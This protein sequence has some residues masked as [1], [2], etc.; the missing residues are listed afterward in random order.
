MLNS[1]EGNSEYE[2]YME[3]VIYDNFANKETKIKFI[4]LSKENTKYYNKYMSQ[5]IKI[6]LKEINVKNL[7]ELTTN[8]Q[9]YYY[10]QGVKLININSLIQKYLISYND[11]K[12]LDLLFMSILYSYYTKDFMH[13]DIAKKE[14]IF[15]KDYNNINKIE[16]NNNIIS[17]ILK[18][19]KLYIK[20][21]LKLIKF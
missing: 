14:L 5:N 17:K 11:Y 19:S 18:N 1:N 9:N 10:F 8:P 3:S 16:L 7:V 2:K 15:T 21:D 12:L 4:N 13:I 6:L 20:N